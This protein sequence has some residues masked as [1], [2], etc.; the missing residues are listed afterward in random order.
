[1]NNENYFSETGSSTWR[2]KIVG[3]GRGNI[4]H[5][6]IHLCVLDDSVKVRFYYYSADAILFVSSSIK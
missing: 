6:I 4:G 3:D 2:K 5:C 1:M